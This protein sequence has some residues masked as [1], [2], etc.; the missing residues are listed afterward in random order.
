VGEDF[1]SVCATSAPF[2]AS[3]LFS[4]RAAPVVM[5]GRRRHRQEIKKI[6]RGAVCQ[7][8]IVDFVKDKW[9]SGSAKSRSGRA[10]RQAGAETERVVTSLFFASSRR[11]LQRL[12]GDFKG[13]DIFVRES[14]V[15]HSLY[16]LVRQRRRHSKHAG[17]RT[18]IQTTPPCT[19]LNHSLGAV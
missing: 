5:A 12:V 3:H 7:R 15:V 16:P 6:R 19:I 11:S 13:E 14:R 17:G 9:K 1:F 8:L 18:I 2:E 10:G 4:S